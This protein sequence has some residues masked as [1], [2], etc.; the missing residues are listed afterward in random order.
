MP[1]EI[2]VQ[3][4][5]RAGEADAMKAWC[6]QEFGP[7]LLAEGGA[8]IDRLIVNLALPVR[9]DQPY[10]SGESLQGDAF[11]LVLQVG[12]ASGQPAGPAMASIAEAFARHSRQWHAYRVTG[13]EVLNRFPIGG[14]AGK[15]PG[16]KLLR[17]LY[18]FDDLPDAA[19]KRMWT[20]HSELAVKVHVG[21][22][23]YAR[24]WVDEVLTPAAPGIRGVSDLHF[25]DAQALRDRYFDSPRGREEIWHDIGHFICAGTQR[26]F[27]EEHVLR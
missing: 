2:M 16:I 10:G 17:G 27:G 4:C 11:D 20:H 1:M 26:F 25:P 9:P 7:R 13:T 18:I 15:S 5:S 8:G 23:R 3:A 24:Y 22:A 21:L 19:A 12:V 14:A 6:L